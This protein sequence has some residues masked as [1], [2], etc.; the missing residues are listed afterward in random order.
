MREKRNAYRVLVENPQGKRPLGRS[1]RR[2]EDNDKRHFRV[3]ALESVNWIHLAE[4]WDQ[5]INLVNKLSG[6]INCAEFLD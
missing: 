3:I 5:V 2:W 1:R 4:N 6:F